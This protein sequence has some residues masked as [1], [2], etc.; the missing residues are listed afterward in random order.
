[1]VDGPSSHPDKFPTEESQE[2]ERRR[3]LELIE[4]LVKWENVNNQEILAEAQAEILKSTNGNPPPVL[5]NAGQG[6]PG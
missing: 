4:K 1:M 5:D 3:L 6:L 2:Q